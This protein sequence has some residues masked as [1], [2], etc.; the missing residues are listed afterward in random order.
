MYDSIPGFVE[1]LCSVSHT[2]SNAKTLAKG[3][4][5]NIDE[6]QSRSGMSLKVIVDLSQVHQFALFNVACQ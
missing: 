6:I 2:G 4:G 5:S 1:I 3:A